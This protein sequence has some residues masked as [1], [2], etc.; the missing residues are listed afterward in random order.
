MSWLSTISDFV[1]IFS[2]PL[3]WTVTG[4]TLLV[5][6]VATLI[7]MNLGLILA[8]GLLRARRSWAKFLDALLSAFVA[9]PAVVFGLLALMFFSSTLFEGSQITL[10]IVPMMVA[11]ATLLT[12]LAATLSLT[13]LRGRYQGIGEE[14]A[15]LGASGGQVFGALMRDCWPALIA[16]AVLV[17]SRGVAEVGTVLIV[18][19]NIEG[20]TQ[21]LT[22]LIAE[23]ARNGAYEPA[24]A[25]ALILI[26]LALIL[27][28]IVRGLQGRHTR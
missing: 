17:F 22:T 10:T 11:Q 23:R 5:S 19:G 9:I 18:G 12:P 27:S 3:V 25:L 1:P 2:D 28:L 21:V 7:A 14:L 8:R 13:V 15:S 4:R 26:G 16:T 20:R 24:V 6:F